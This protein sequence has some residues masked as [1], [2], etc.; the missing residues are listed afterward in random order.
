MWGVLMQQRQTDLIG[1]GKTINFVVLV[2]TLVTL[3]TATRFD[4]A[5]SGAMSLVV[6]ELAECIYMQCR[7]KQVI[8]ISAQ[9]AA[10]GQNE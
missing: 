9:P 6:G 2:L 7:F 10:A 4:P 5:A 3:L 8:G 1:K